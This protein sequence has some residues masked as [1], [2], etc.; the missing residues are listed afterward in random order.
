ME[1]LTSIKNAKNPRKKFLATDFLL[2]WV[3]ELWVWTLELIDIQLLRCQCL[4][5]S[6]LFE[7][8]N[9]LT[10]TILTESLHLQ[11]LEIPVAFGYTFYFRPLHILF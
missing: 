4:E 11:L 6:E 3:Q 2:Q 9:N 7:V 5:G 10:D 8:L 1:S